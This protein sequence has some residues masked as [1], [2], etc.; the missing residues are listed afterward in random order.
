MAYEGGDGIHS[1]AC[2]RWHSC[3]EVVSI[4]WTHSMAFIVRVY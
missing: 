2:I 3:G 1:M 4:R